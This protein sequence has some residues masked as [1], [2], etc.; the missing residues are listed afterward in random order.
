MHRSLLTC[1]LLLCPLAAAAQ[2]PAPPAAVSDC[3][4]IKNDMAYNQC[5]A[6]FG[7]KH[8]ERGARGSAENDDGPGL[9]RSGRG[10]PSARRSRGSRQAA[11]FDVV[12]SRRRGA[13]RAVTGSSRLAVGQERASRKRR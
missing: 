11:A 13:T 8:G 6:S 4:K 1:L 12:S 3:E 5:L 10:G 7:P 9:R 2:A